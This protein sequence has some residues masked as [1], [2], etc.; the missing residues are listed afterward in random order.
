[1]SE[2]FETVRV[3]WNCGPDAACHGSPAGAEPGR[4][5]AHAVA[6]L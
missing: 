6:P 4:E 3:G 5:G 1:M 2:T